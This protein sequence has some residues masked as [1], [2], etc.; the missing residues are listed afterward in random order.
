M[1]YPA[2]ASSISLWERFGPQTRG[3]NWL[4]PPG[5]AKKKEPLPIAGTGPAALHQLP[6]A[7]KPGLASAWHP[8]D[9]T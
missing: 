5:S 7:A 1:L 2:K 9:R 8:D 4:K 3:M 6:L